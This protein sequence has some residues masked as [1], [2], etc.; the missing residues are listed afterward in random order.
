MIFYK[1]KNDSVFWRK[2]PNYLPLQS[3][4]FQSDKAPYKHAVLSSWP[5]A[6]PFLSP[7]PHTSAKV[8]SVLAF[9][10]SFSH[11]R[12]FLIN[13]L[14]LTDMSFPTPVFNFSV[15]CV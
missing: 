5:P 9:Q 2:S 10:S 11:L 3:S 8:L 4:P 7:Q 14:L 6:C 13:D 1:V 15:T 12:S